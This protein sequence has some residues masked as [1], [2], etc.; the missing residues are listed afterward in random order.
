MKKM[1]MKKIFLFATLAVAL[2][3]AKEQPAGNDG[4]GQIAPK[5]GLTQMQFRASSTDPQ[6]RTSLSE[7]NAILWST[8][9]RINV[10][11]GSSFATKTDFTVTSLSNEN[12]QATFEGL[13]EISPAYYALFPAQNGAAITSEGIITAE[14]PNVQNAV[15]GSFGP[16]ANLSVAYIAA[17]E[18]LVFK[19]VGALLAVEINATDV[20]GLRLASNS[21]EALSGTALIDYNDGDPTADVVSAYDYVQTTVSGPGTYYFIVYPGSHEEGFTL[22]LTKEGHFASYS[23]P[24]ALEIGRNENILL[25]TIPAT[26]PWCA[27]FTPGEALEIRGSAEAGQSA[28]YIPAG[29]WNAGQAK[30]SDNSDLY[31]YE[32][33]TLLEAGEPFYF[34]A[35]EGALFTLNASGNAVKAISDG[36]KAAYSVAEDGIYRIRMYLPDGEAH[37]KKVTRVA[38]SEWAVTGQDLDYEGQGVWK[39]NI[40]LK[41]G[42][43][44]WDN[45]YKFNVHFSDG[46]NQFYGRMYDNV[47][48]NNSPVYGT[49]DATYFYVQPCDNTD[50]WEPCFKFPS[51]Y[52][53]N[54]DRYYGDLYLYLNNDYTHYTHEVVNI[55]DTQ[56]LP[57]IT[58]GENIYIGGSYEAGQKMVY[59]IASTFNTTMSDFGE[60]SGLDGNP[61][62]DYN[63][64]IFTWL[65]AGE[66]FYFTNSG[67]GKYFAPN[68]DGTEMIKIS[69]PTKAVYTAKSTGAWRIR[70]DFAT[71]KLNIRRIDQV[72]TELNY[73]NAY[74]TV[75]STYAG[76]GKWSVNG[77]IVGD[78]GKYGRTLFTEYIFK[79]WFNRDQAGNSIDYWQVYGSTSTKTGSADPSDDGSYWNLQPYT[80]QNWTNV[81]FYPSWTVDPQDNGRYTATITLDMGTTYGCY[82][83][84]FTDVT[85]T[86]Q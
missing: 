23:S 56:D 25:A 10:F 64:E 82:T 15:A 59:N 44:T 42:S 34:E 68:S 35:E 61:Y 31:N 78:P 70:C 50:N 69:D 79:I 38:F 58:P 47:A 39:H 81:F 55:R 74:Y 75:F 77:P 46:S 6:T 9:D 32:I 48:P 19:N 8:S 76:E 83:H 13:A 45:R 40:P 67:N 11:S 57:D 72:R 63:Y 30:Y 54:E 18:D 52:E 85:D 41:R 71:G 3:C 43:N 5:E 16:K 53:I 36:S 4:S 21:Y 26:V 20:T 28:S 29:Y 84:R 33:F 73:D 1:D 14:L 7:D 12:R 49:T 17:G 37:V 86:R 24:K 66:A 80:G 62:S 60:V 22:S 65:E 2:S 27:E 51:T